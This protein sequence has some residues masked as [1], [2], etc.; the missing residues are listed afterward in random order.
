MHRFTVSLLTLVLAGI[1]TAPRAAE[2]QLVESASQ[3]A[4][5]ERA[6]EQRF[7]AQ[8]SSQDQLGWLKLMAAEPNQVGSPHDKANADW[9]VD[10]F[11][12][13]GWDARIET[14]QVLYPTPISEAV[15]MLGPKPFKV[16]LQE[17]PIPGDTSAT[18]KQ[19]ALPAYLVYQG[20]GDVTAPL[21]YV[22][23]GTVAD[24]KQLDLMGISVKGKIVITRYGQVW[25]G[26]KPLLA[27]MHGAIGC[28]IYSD[29]ID[30]WHPRDGQCQAPHPTGGDE[31]HQN[32]RL[33]DFLW[34][35][36]G[37]FVGDVGTG[38]AGELAR[39]SS[40]HLS[41]RAGH[42]AGASAGEIQLGSQACL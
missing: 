41:R 31:P 22:N 29:P 6:L 34:R 39:C 17:A 12:K 30:D 4:Q 21:V 16:T 11:R 8:L 24:Y 18:A 40:H 35:C 1:L 27:Q 5:A 15:E 14:Y 13:F 28:L 26:V 10:Q 19:Y 42:A 20:D 9:E 23:Y 3:G 2:P 38:C 36:P 37:A 25:R 7:D 32:S 33:T